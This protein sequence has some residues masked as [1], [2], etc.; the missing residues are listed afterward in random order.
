MGNIPQAK[1]FICIQLHA[2]LENPSGK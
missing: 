2:R 1:C